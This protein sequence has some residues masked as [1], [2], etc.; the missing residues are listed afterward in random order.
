MN[1]LIAGYVG[2][3]KTG[4]GRYTDNIIDRMS[5][6]QSKDSFIL[7]KNKDYDDYSTFCNNVAVQPYK[8]SKYSSMGNLLWHQLIYPFYCWRY[9]ADVSFIP[10]VTLLL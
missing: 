1:T 6:E 9:K 5:N 8:V 7:L 4:I 10:N 2:S 3:H